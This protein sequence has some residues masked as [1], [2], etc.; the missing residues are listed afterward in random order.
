MIKRLA[1]NYNKVDELS[2]LLSC[3]FLSIFHPSLRL[4][5]I[6]VSYLLFISNWVLM[7]WTLYQHILSVTS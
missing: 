2:C 3:T 4:W 1:I 6:L 5:F 7:L